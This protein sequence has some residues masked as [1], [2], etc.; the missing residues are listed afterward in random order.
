AAV[1]TLA[2][3]FVLP[4]DRAL[5]PELV[6]P[7]GAERPDI[8]VQADESAPIIVES[9]ARAPLATEPTAD[10]VEST[11]SPWMHVEG[12][13]CELDGRRIPGVR[14]VFERQRDDG[15]VRT[16]DAPTAIAS[17]DGSFALDVPLGAG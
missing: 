14:V 13:V 4:W 10:E 17:A 9:A 12:R 2:A 11:R 15:F 1:V 7:V 6:R 8:V 5:D 16:A 3:V